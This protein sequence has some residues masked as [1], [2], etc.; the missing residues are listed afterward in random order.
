MKNE[1][2]NILPIELSYIIKDKFYSLR[3]SNTICF[4]FN[5]VMRFS[6]DY[7]EINENEG[8]YKVDGYHILRNSVENTKNMF[9]LILHNFKYKGKVMINTEVIKID[10]KIDKIFDKKI[11]LLKIIEI[12]FYFTEKDEIYINSIYSCCTLPSTGHSILHTISNYFEI[13]KKI[14]LT[15]VKDTPYLKMGF[16]GNE[17]NDE[18]EVGIEA[19]NKKYIELNLKT[20]FI[21]DY[22]FEK[23]KSKIIND[24]KRKSKRRQSSKRKSKKKHSSKRKSKR[25]QSSK[26]KSK[27][28]I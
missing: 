16:V 28:K 21:L 7:L 24:G 9:R 8:V 10:E 18:M 12:E 13:I 1:N 23:I 11:N 3:T 4:I 15:A 19:L 17:K 14:K 2:I 22:K 20:N 6:V 25:R 5:N 27:K 26:R